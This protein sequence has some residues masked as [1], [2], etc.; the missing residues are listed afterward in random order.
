MV[1]HRVELSI[2][3]FAK[4]KKSPPPPRM[5]EIIVPPKYSK[6]NLH[7]IDIAL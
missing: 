5:V 1:T 2:L 6:D 4:K 3:R 7:H